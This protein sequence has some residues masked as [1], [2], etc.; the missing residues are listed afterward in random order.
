MKKLILTIMLLGLVSGCGQPLA[1]FA[2][3]FGSGVALKL[4]EANR[5]M[6]ALGKDIAE[7]NKKAGEIDVLIE[8]D[9]LVLVNALDPNLGGELTKFL[10]NVKALEGKYD[11][12][13]DEKGR[14]DW[15]RLLMVAGL[16][17]FGGWNGKRAF[18][19]KGNSA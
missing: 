4:N 18:F 2:A 5:A 7:L 19:K 1:D 6:D 13:K 12:F 9:P 8:K 16:S 3:G 14:V 10:L 11:E 17:L 15:E